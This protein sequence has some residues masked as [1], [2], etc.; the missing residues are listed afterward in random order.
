MPR[1]PQPGSDDGTW[2]DILNDFLQVEHNADGSQ[3][4][5][6]QSTVIDLE[7]DLAAKQDT[8]SAGTYV[9]VASD[10]TIT[11]LKTFSRTAPDIA[12][13]VTS[14]FTA[15]PDTGGAQGFIL[16]RTNNARPLG[17]V[18]KTAG[19]VDTA[20]A[21]DAGTSDLILYWSPN[22]PGDQLRVREGPH[23][24]VGRSVGHPSDTYRL[25]LDAVSGDPVAMVD[26]VHLTANTTSPATRVLR[27]STEATDLF[28]V[29]TTGEVGVGTLS[30]GSLVHVVKSQDATT[31][32]LFQNLNNTAAAR[33]SLR[34]SSASKALFLESFPAGFSTPSLAG[35]SMIYTNTAS[36]LLLGGGN[37]E[38][39]RLDSLGNVVLGTGALVTSATDRFVYLP[40]MAGTPTGVPT[41]KSGMVPV[42]IDTTT[43][44][45]WAYIGGAWKSV[46][47]T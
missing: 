30:P 25:R 46:T 41:A 7:D 29:K 44:K 47:L 1:L 42:H 10:E 12:Q 3:K 40:S 33:V 28:T 27:I 19:V 5:L 9:E 34:L 6:P 38:R 37:A 2:G 23:I 13:T 21:V 22:T 24:L 26:L 8:I 17:F 15:V 31:Q 35:H 36:D 11:G 43:S 14:Q 4:P 20:I 45:L 18:F 16:T 32:V 39:M